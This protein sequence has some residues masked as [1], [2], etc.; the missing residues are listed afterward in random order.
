M[1]Q[2]GNFKSILKNKKMDAY[3]KHNIKQDELKT[4]RQNHMF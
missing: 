4:G 2:D 1:S 3:G